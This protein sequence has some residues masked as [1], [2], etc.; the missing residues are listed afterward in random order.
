MKN[1][2]NPLQEAADP[3]LLIRAGTP[4]S[5]NWPFSRQEGLF[6]AACAHGFAVAWAVP[7]L[8]ESNT[9]KPIAAQSRIFQSAEY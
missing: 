6:P 5:L 9:Q 2:I 4:A 7:Y 3:T 8:R 1:L